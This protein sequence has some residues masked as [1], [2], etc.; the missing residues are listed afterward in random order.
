MSIFFLGRPPCQLKTYATR[1]SIFFV[2][3]PPCQL[4]TYA[5][6]IS[7]FR[8]ERPP[9][10]LITYTPRLNLVP[11]GRSI[12]LYPRGERQPRRE[13]RIGSQCLYRGKETGKLP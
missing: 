9:G 6:R 10:Q 11:I 8:I 2:G 12:C 1:I 7:I 3:R 13:I 5:T 4:K